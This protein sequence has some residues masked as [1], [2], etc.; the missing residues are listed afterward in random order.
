MDARLHERT[1]R[2]PGADQLTPRAKRGRPRAVPPAGATNGCRPGA[3][4]ALLDSSQG[5]GNIS[6]RTGMSSQYERR[7]REGKI[8]PPHASG[9]DVMKRSAVLSLAALLAA[10]SPLP[11]A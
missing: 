10:A 3:V 6:A 1:N 7:R 8:P 9:R 4:G 11:A 5:A 2:A